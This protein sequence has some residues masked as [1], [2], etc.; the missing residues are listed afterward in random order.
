[1]KKLT[2][3]SAIAIV[4]ISSMLFGQSDR[5]KHCIANAAF[6]YDL[7]ILKA[8]NDDCRDDAEAYCDREHDLWLAECLRAPY[9]L[10]NKGK[11]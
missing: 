10:G 3:T 1:M 9:E 11:F 6:L 5:A 4:G 2:L 7:C 8:C